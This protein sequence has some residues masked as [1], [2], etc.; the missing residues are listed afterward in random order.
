[1]IR[2]NSHRRWDEKRIASHAPRADELIRWWCLHPAGVVM[3][4]RWLMVPTLG[5]QSLVRES[6]SLLALQIHVCTFLQHLSTWRQ[7]SDWGDSRGNKKVIKND[8]DIWPRNEIFTSYL[9]FEQKTNNDSSA[10][11][12]TVG[13]YLHRGMPF[14]VI[15]QFCMRQQLLKNA[16][17]RVRCLEMIGIILLQTKKQ[18]KV[19][20][21]LQTSQTASCPSLPWTEIC[22]NDASKL[23]QTKTIQGFDVIYD[24]SENLK[25]NLEIFE[26]TPQLLCAVFC[27]Q[28]ILNLQSLKMETAQRKPKRP[29]YIP[30][31][32][33]KPFKYQCF[34]CPFT[35]NE[36]S[37]LFNH[38]KYNLCKNSISLVSQKHGQTNR[39]AKAET[40]IV[41]FKTKDC[42][43]PPLN[44]QANVNEKD[45]P[46]DGKANETAGVGCDST[47]NKD[48]QS[49]TNPNTPTE[50]NT[51]GKEAIY[52]PRLSAFSLVTPKNDGAGLKLR[53]ED[54]QAP[55]PTNHPG[56]PWA[57]PPSSL[58]PFSP[59]TISEYPSYLLPDRALYPPYYLERNYYANEPN[60][61]FQPEFAD[62]QRPQ[63][64]L[65]PTYPY[66]YF[67]LQPG[68]PLQYTLY[69][70]YELQLPLTEPR[71][72]PLDLHS[73]A[74]RPRDYEGQYMHSPPTHDSHTAST[75]EKSDQSTDKETRL[76]P[77]E[78]CSALGSPDRPSQAHLVQKDTEAS[79]NTEE[80]T[81]D[82]A[83]AVKQ[84]KLRQT[85]PAESPLQLRN[86]HLDER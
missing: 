70:P 52:L 10:A 32:P 9:S 49:V 35:C 24:D 77:R 82:Q 34:Q 69:R 44:V 20:M 53:A 16:G 46:E 73:P 50:E 58:K 4:S 33:G 11:I 67:P 38:M 40:K 66:R 80:T 28:K 3:G 48:S 61:S 83:K 81:R 57:A 59:T 54:S 29:H 55:T 47:V 71:Y 62:P 43:S 23:W 21:K 19:P 45:L 13:V 85:G 60:S 6:R 78:G 37:H 8:T 42:P 31:P 56:F 25:W 74:F 15:C 17:L 30:R 65:F 79:D 39:Q 12:Q 75:E 68:H 18:E 5:T 63:A 76:S 51:E 36:K 84:T 26:T 41:P 7:F 27:L 72:L 1:M 14:K 2:H 64:S 22:K 86:Q